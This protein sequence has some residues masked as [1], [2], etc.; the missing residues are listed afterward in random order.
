MNRGSAELAERSV[1]SAGP[2]AN[3]ESSSQF[4]VLSCQRVDATPQQRPLEW[5]TGA[6]DRWRRLSW[7]SGQTWQSD[8]CRLARSL[9]PANGS[10]RARP[11]GSGQK[12]S[13]QLFHAEFQ[14]SRGLRAA[15]GAGMTCIPSCLREGDAPAE[16]ILL[17]F[18][19]KCPEWESLLRKK[20]AGGRMSAVTSLLPGGEGGRRPDEGVA[21]TIHVEPHSLRNSHDDSNSIV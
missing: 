7:P 15:E 8:D 11:P 9:A 20:V 6:S 16:P 18:F 3:G 14:S 5:T 1:D 4:S 13:W 12:G 10:A 21:T 17:F 2:A 19:P